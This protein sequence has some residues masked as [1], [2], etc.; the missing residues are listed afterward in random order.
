MGS[1][2]DEID[3][4]KAQG[5]R[6]RWGGFWLYDNPVDRTIADWLDRQD[7]NATEVAKRAI[8]EAITGE[9]ATSRDPVADELA[10]L[11]TEIQR[12]RAALQS[13]A[14]LPAPIPDDDSLSQAEADE[15]YNK[16]GGMPD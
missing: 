5:L 3:A 4:L 7:V 8:Y 1:L 12:L 14:A 11:R 13:G 16:L 15:I 2:Q 9:A 10:D 6:V